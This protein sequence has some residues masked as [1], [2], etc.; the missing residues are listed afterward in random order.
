MVEIDI[1]RLAQEADKGHGCA[2]KAELQAMS[3]E[4]SIKVMRQIADHNQQDP[5]P[6]THRLY[7]DST[8]NTFGPDISL[9]RAAPGSKY[10][11][12]DKLI[13]DRLYISDVGD[14][15][16]GQRTIGCTDYSESK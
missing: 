4:D 14:N 7:F 3:Y 15:K 13:H 6:E 9:W 1:A 10:S 8:G 16:A 2:L 12:G 11:W 5:N